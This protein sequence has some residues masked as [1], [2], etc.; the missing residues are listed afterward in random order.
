MRNLLKFSFIAASCVLTISSAATAKS[1][2]NWVV[3]AAGANGGLGYSQ[4]G[5][6]RAVTSRVL[7][8]CR[9]TNGNTGANTGKCGLAW[10][11]TKAFLIVIQCPISETRDFTWGWS[12]NTSLADARKGAL[13]RMKGHNNSLGYLT[14][15]QDCVDRI[16]Y[17]NGKVQLH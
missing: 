4:G 1:Q 2:R 15:E 3:I 6:K 5:N 10:G 16:T 12:S 13:N 11:E 14:R 8:Q 17:S 9:A 7:T